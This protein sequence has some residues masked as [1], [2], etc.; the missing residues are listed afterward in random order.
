MSTQHG[1][2]DPKPSSGSGSCLSDLLSSETPHWNQGSDAGSTSWIQRKDKW[3]SAGPRGRLE[4][5]LK[6][7]GNRVC[8]DCGSPDPKW[9]SLSL[10]VFI[11][12]KCS[13]VHRSLGV[14]ISKVLSVKLDEWTDEQVDSLVNLGGNI[15]ANNKY[16]A[17]LPDN[18]KKPGPDSSIEERSDF[19]RRKYEMLQFLEG[20]EQII[21]PHQPHQRT[22]SSTPQS[23]SG[24]QVTQEK[25]QYEKQPTR[26]RSGHKFRNSWGRKD[27][28]NHKSTKKSNSLAGMVEF[29]GLVKVNVVKGTNLAVRDVLSSDPYVILALG[30]QSVKTRVIKNN[31]NPVWNERLMLSIPENIPPLKVLVY[32]KDTFTTDDFMGDAEIDIQPLVAAAK[33]YEKS[34]IQESMQLGKWVASKDNTLV[35]DG[36][37][38]LIDGKVKQEISLRLQNVERGVLEIELECVPLTQ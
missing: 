8:A 16:E 15:V 22:S 34:E 32:D 23:S 3:K 14:H 29:V 4:R 25:K 36:V 13:G 12:I 33:A 10:G 1:K 31:L 6:E 18:L 35:K 27:S 26:H 20:N 30:Q 38:T 5:L 17:F 2:S 9:V 21:C 19:I 37:I 11:C 7:S 28:D 24:H